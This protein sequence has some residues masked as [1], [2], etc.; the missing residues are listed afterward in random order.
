MPFPPLWQAGWGGAVGA[1]NNWRQTATEEQL[2]KKK[3]KCENTTHLKISD[4]YDHHKYTPQDD[5]WLHNVYYS[6]SSNIVY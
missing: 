5:G 4:P 2:Q 6:N 3:T 1:D